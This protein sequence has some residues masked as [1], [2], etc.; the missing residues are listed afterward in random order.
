MAESVDADQFRAALRQFASGVTVVTCRV[1]GVD[2]AMTASAFTAV[3]LEPALVL[4]CVN[5]RARFAEALAG[6]SSW[7]VSVLAEQSQEAATWFATSG[8]PLVGQLDR[9]PHSRGASGVALLDGSLAVLECHTQGVQ[10]AGDHDI[11]VGAVASAAVADSGRPLLYWQGDYR[12][13][14]PH[15]G[16]SVVGTA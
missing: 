7:G 4:V 11:V 8:R 9:F 12:R 15:A 6:T 16:A 5:R 14:E 2:H 3:S 10:E 1:A 13:L